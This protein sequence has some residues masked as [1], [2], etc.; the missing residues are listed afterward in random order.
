MHDEQ[1]L[2]ERIARLVRSV[3]AEVPPEVEAKIREAA[4]A[5]RPRA[6]RIWLRRPFWLALVPSA[7][8]VVLAAV[9]LL[10]P[11]RKP[12]EPIAEIRTE[13]ELAD[14]NIKIVFIQKPDFNLFKEN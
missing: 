1:K 14:K 2:D 7:A 8:A 12:A 13:F 10:P 9:A 5:L 6:K 3:A 4:A 11:P